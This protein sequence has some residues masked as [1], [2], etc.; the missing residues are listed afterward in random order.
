MK[1]EEKSLKRKWIPICHYCNHLGHIRPHCF[2]NLV[3]LRKKSNKNIHF[4]II[5]MIKKEDKFGAQ[6]KRESMLK[7]IVLQKH[8][9]RKMV[10]GTRHQTR[11]KRN[12]KF[13]KIPM[14]DKMSNN[15]SHK[16]SNEIQA[17]WKLIK[18][19][20]VG[21]T[22]GEND[23]YVKREVPINKDGPEDVRTTCAQVVTLDVHEDP[24]SKLVTTVDANALRGTVG[25]SRGATVEDVKA[26]LLRMWY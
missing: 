24:T 2:T 3:N 7:L 10:N 17:I 6:L 25:V 15:M 19:K 18:E 12:G 11:R 14:L 1:F 13:V 16:K 22:Q 20:Y 9:P 5:E 26:G 8:D 4:H 21:N 23:S